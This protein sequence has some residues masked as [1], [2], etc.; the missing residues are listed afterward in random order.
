[1]LVQAYKRIFEQAE[2]FRETNSD[3]DAERAFRK[4]D[5]LIVAKLP[6]DDGPVIGFVGGR[7]MRLADLAGDEDKIRAYNV[8]AI[9]ANDCIFKI[10][11]LGVLKEYENKG[12]G[13][14]LLETLLGHV[15]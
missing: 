6:S 5:L 11:E 3:E 2:A 15:R 12:I 13:S 1:S 14:R 4:M 10:A 7:N 8:L 9:M